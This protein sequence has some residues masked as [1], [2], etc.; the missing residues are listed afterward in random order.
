MKKKLE[1]LEIGGQVYISFG[2][3]EEDDLLEIEL[4]G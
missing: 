1:L 4:D 3:N 2:Y